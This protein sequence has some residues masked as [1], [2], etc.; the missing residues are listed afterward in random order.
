MLELLNLTPNLP[1]LEQSARDRRERLFR[2]EDEIG[3]GSDIWKAL[4]THT[5]TIVVG[6]KS[7]THG[8][9]ITQTMWDPLKRRRSV[10]RFRDLQ[11]DELA[12]LFSTTQKVANLVEKHFNATSLT[13]AIQDGPEAGQTV[14]HVHVHVLPRKQGD[15]EQNDSIY[16]ECIIVQ[17]ND[18]EATVNELFFAVQKRMGLRSVVVL[19]F[20]LDKVEQSGRPGAAWSIQQAASSTLIENTV[21]S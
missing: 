17:I 1:K 13:I 10:E 15:F 12:D 11:P 3:P 6:I 7:I 21:S 9:L 18:S 2:A 14:K 8:M 5:Y 16:D 4:P 19:S 20:Y